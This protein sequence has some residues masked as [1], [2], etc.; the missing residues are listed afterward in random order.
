[1][2]EF[3]GT[4]GGRF[5]V[6]AS[7]IAAIVAGWFTWLWQHDNKVESRVLAKIEQRTNENVDKAQRARASVQN[8]PIDQLDDRYRRD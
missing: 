1:M 5:A 2:I 4:L 8:V 3:F 6:G 7:I